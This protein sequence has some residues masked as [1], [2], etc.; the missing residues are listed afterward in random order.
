M[1]SESRAGKSLVDSRDYK[2]PQ[3][4]ETCSTL[5]FSKWRHDGLQYLEAHVTWHHATEFM[6][7]IRQQTVEIAEAVFYQ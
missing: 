7:E 6:H 5:Q 1:H 3:M 2:S 4:P